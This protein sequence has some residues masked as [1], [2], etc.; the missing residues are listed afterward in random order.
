LDEKISKTVNKKYLF[1][2][3]GLILALGLVAFVP[4]SEASASSGDE[5]ITHPGGFGGPA[6]GPWSD[7]YL[8]EALGITVEQLQAAYDDASTKAI[9]Q[10]VEAGYITQEQADLMAERGFGFFGKRGFGG[11]RWGAGDAIDFN[12][13]LAEALDISVEK[14]QD[15]QDAAAEAALA[16][17]VEDGSLTEEQAELV[18]ARR[19]LEKSIEKRELMAKALGISVEELEA[20]REEGK[21]MAD[22]IDEL[23]LELDA[24]RE[25][26]QAAYQEAVEQAVE[27]G[28]ITQ[29]QADLILEGGFGPGMRGGPCGG[30]GGR[31]RFPHD[32]GFPPPGEDG[33]KFPGRPGF[34]TEPD[35]EL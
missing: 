20:A 22:L 18:A 32:G 7:E 5:G 34:T 4:L 25:A 28:V 33:M 35:S 15:A 27:D 11:P 1:V 24:V 26:K 29:E 21:S 13:L 17:A 6:G 3:L 10:A 16:A 14:L 12:A 31:G 8:A 19:A 2:A 23:G 9:T 30:A